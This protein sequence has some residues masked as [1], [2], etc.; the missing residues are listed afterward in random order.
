MWSATPYPVEILDCTLRD[1]G[2]LID[3]AFLDNQIRGIV[4]RLIRAKIDIIEV[5]FLRE[6]VTY[7]GNS[8]FFRWIEQAEAVLPEGS[9]QCF[10]LFWDYGYYKIDDLPAVSGRFNWGIRYGFTKKNFLHN[11]EAIRREMLSIK[12]KGYRLYFQSVDTV[13][14]SASELLE[15]IALANEILPYSFGIV[16]T[17]GSMFQDDLERIFSLVDYELS[18]NIGIDFHGHNNMQLAFALAQH[19]VKLCQGRRRLILDATLEGM[20]KCVGNLGTELAAY[21]LNQKCGGNYEFDQLLNATDE[22]IDTIKQDHPW[23]YSLPVLMAG[24]YRAHLNNVIYLTSKYRLSSRDIRKILL[25][26]DENTRLRYDYDNIHQ[27]YQKYF[28]MLT[29]DEDSIQRLKLAFAGKNILVLAPGISITTYVERIEQYA[30]ENC[31]IAI[32]VNFIDRRCPYAFFGNDRR[33][34]DSNLNFADQKIILTSNVTQRTGKEVVINYTNC[35]AESGNYF[36]NSTLMLLNLLAN[37]DVSRIG[38]A[39]MDGFEKN[40]T[41]YFNE[42]N[43][44]R[45]LEDQFDS[46]NRELEWQVIHYMERTSGRIQVDFVTPS[47]FAPK[48]YGIYNSITR[49]SEQK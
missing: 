32:S 26:I 13:G 1:G 8:T 15:L 46:I 19:C 16:D 29:D 27:V 42:F 12:E 23:G 17:Y 7:T 28:G 21:Y 5:G 36:D 34:Q 43:V 48:S 30:Q 4:N 35:I 47:R 49:G 40:V 18:S 33:Y 10:T 45:R 31:P 2:R 22:F 25:L 39:G 24:I 44:E 9:K 41:N 37:C 11:R 6:K 38:I 14:Y 3:C 20:G